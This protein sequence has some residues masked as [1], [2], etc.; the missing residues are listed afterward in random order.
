MTGWDITYTVCGTDRLD[1]IT[2]LWASLYSHHASLLHDYGE[3]R[4]A[5]E[6]WDR[7]RAR[8]VRWIQDDDGFFVIADRAGDSSLGYAMAHQTDGFDILLTPD[9]IAQVETLCVLPNERSVE[10]GTQL[11]LALGNELRARGVTHLC[12]TALA[13]NTVIAD[14]FRRRGLRDFTLTFFGRTDDA[15]QGF[16]SPSAK[17]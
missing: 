12:A 8:Y 9:R 6:S 17:R 11:A 3:V 14:A 16:A 7:R 13:A 15:Y 2:P 4:S 5:E 10:V 1:D